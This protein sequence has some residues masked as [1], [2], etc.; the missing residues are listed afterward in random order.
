MTWHALHY[1]LKV[2]SEDAVKELFRSSGRPDFDVTDGD[3]RPVG[4][5][6]GTM[7]FVG[8]GKAIRVMEVDGP[9]PVV[10][11]HLSRQPAIRDFERRLEE[12]LA[13]PRDMTS[14]EGARTF[15]Q[16]AGMASVAVHPVEGRP[17][18]TWHGVYYPLRPGSEEAVTELFTGT[19]DG[20]R[21]DLTIRDNT[22]RKVGQVVGTMVFV[23]RE[24]ALRL[25]QVEGPLPA[26]F[27]HMSRQGGART[28]QRSLEGYLAHPQDPAGANGSGRRPFFAEAAV[29]YVLGRR[30]DGP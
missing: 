8:K 4:R 12:H 1:P 5:L 18:V 7:A 11:A 14:P 26:F 15:F 23:G 13:V 3:G 10:A 2:G 9:L 22:G 17:A 28:F 24:K 30:H 19:R 20:R 6:L 27:R 16:R 25:V 29:E 21:P